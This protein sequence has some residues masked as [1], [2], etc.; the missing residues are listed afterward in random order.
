MSNTL[1]TPI[2][3]LEREFPVRV[4]RYALRRGSGG[5]G[6]HRGGDGV[7]RE[8][9][10]LRELTYSLIAERRRHAPAGA[11][12]GAPG[13][14]GEDR[15]D[16]ALVAGK[17]TGRLRRGQRLGIHTPGGGGYGAPASGAAA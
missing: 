15:L 4:V 16:G 1:N 5:A 7:I 8:L 14:R 11:A 3:A 17:S 6:R 2:E 13:A 12:G 10:A 9:E